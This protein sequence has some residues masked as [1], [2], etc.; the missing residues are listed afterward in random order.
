MRALAIALSALALGLAACD[1]DEYCPPRTRIRESAPP[2]PE[3]TG[4]LLYGAG[5]LAIGLASRR[6][7]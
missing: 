6:R 3:P 4:A 5:L 1:E 2:I 7:R